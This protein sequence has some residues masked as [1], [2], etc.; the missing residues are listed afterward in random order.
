MTPQ[1]FSEAMGKLDDRYISE[2][3]SYKK[4]TKPPAW[5]KWG[6]A[7]ACF[8]AVFLAGLFALHPNSG[9]PVSIGGIARNY[10]D[11]QVLE[12]DSAIEWPW[13]YKTAAERYTTIQLEG[14]EYCSR[15]CPVSTSFISELIGIFDVSGYDTYTNQIHKAASEV[16]RI[17]GIS[18]DRIVAVKLGGE[19]YAFSQ[20]QY[21]PP[22][23]LGEVLDSCSLDRT[24]PLSQFTAYDGEQEKGCFRLND[25]TCIWDV[26]NTCRDSEFVEDGSWN[27]GHGAYLSFTATSDALGV[28]KR[29]LKVTEDGYLWT[30]IFD[31]AY[32]FRIGPEAADRIIS[33]AVSHGTESEP[34][35]FLT[36]LAGTL[37]EI[38]EDYILVDDTILCA[39]GSDGMVFKVPLDELRISRCIDFEGVRTGDTVIVYFTGSIDPDSENTV[40]GAFSMVRGTISAGEL[41]V[42]E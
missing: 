3:A 17:D 5:A 9:S 34:E 11:M 13:E 8:S 36:S 27:E 40:E 33:Y 19:F 14:K 24:L 41:Y 29:A 15:G 21:V 1:T 16:Y 39:D 30:N 7:A 22:A 37:T 2:A 12:S 25:D 23:T 35:P 10:K 4:R 18:Q 6:A 28:Y 26:L 31:F 32:S 42:P 20:N 38:S